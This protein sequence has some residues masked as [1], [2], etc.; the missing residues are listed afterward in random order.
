MDRRDVLRL[1]GAG[2]ALAA[3]GD[4]GWAGGQGGHGEPFASTRPDAVSLSAAEWKKHLTPVEFRILRES[5]T[6]R[7]FTG[8]LWDNKGD[9]VYVCAGCALPLYDSKTKFKSGTGWP[10]YWAPIGA[11]MVAE[12]IDGTLGMVRTELLCARCGG[13]LGH[14]FPD[15]PPPTGM[16]HCINSFSMDFVPREHAGEVGPVRLGGWDGPD[17]QRGADAPA[18]A[19]PEGGEP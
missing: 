15:G 4:V 14:V 6:E 11:D 10:S 5:G 2:A 16:R 17:R 8:D 12:R 7:A 3:C 1:I 13:H 18:A 9:G 19:A